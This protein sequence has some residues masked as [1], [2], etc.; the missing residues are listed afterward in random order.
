MAAAQRAIAAPVPVAFAS[1][2]AATVRPAS[3]PHHSTDPT[4]VLLILWVAGTLVLALRLARNAIRLRS[5]VIRAAGHSPILTTAHSRAGGRGHP[6]PVDPLAGDVVDDWTRARAPA[7]YSPMEFSRVSRRHTTRPFSSPLTS[8]TQRVCSRSPSLLAGRRPPARR[9]RARVRRRRAS[10][11]PSTFGLRRARARPCPQ[12]QLLSG[13]PFPWPQPTH[14]WSPAV[15]SI[16]NPRNSTALFQPAPRGPRQFVNR[17]HSNAAEHTHSLASVGGR[18]RER[19]L[20]SG[21]RFS[22]PTARL[23]PA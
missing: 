1:A 18:L 2:T 7:L 11:P 19:P 13:S 20:S 23:Y 10:A 16:L 6:Q 14:I 9:K 12:V 8:A 21:S 22:D 5:I 17:C 4:Q 3:R 15:K